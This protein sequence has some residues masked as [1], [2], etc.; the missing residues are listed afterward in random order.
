MLLASSGDQVSCY[1]TVCGGW[2]CQQLALVQARIFP[3][4]G[5]LTCCVE[6]ECRAGPINHNRVNL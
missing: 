6:V 2:W 3:A 1:T 4:T 5:E